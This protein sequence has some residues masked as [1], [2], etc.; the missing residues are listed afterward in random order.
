MYKRQVKGRTC[1]VKASSVDDGTLAEALAA[2]REYLTIKKSIGTAEADE[3][4]A[5]EL[6]AARTRMHDLSALQTI[7]H[8]SQER[9][10]ASRMLGFTSAAQQR[11]VVYERQYRKLRLILLALRDDDSPF[12]RG[13]LPVD[14][15]ISYLVPWRVSN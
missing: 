6:T 9:K 2:V 8:A 4:V 14:M 10:V 1:L 11:A 13:G 3:A 15:I 5:H 12:G 7:R